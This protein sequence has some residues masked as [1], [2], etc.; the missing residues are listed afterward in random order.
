MRSNLEAKVSKLNSVLLSGIDSFAPQKS[1]SVS[2]VWHAPWYNDGLHAMK[3]SCHKMEHMW[4][5]SGVTVH[6]QAWKDSLH[7]FKAGIASA[8]SGYFCKIIHNNQNKPRQ[9]FNSIN[10]LLNSNSLS[11]VIASTHLCNR[12]HDFFGTKIDKFG[13][14]SLLYW[15]YF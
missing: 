15:Y 8:R 6:Y 9:L 12:F 14:Y 2:F 3:T 13:K 7:E 5:L 4:C 1:R 11:P 10:K